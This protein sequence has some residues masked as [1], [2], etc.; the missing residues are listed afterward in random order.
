MVSREILF[1]GKRVDNGDWVEGGFTFDAALVPRITIIDSSGLGL[2]FI[3]VI[4]DSVGQLIYRIN[5]INVFDG[6]IFGF[7][8]S[9]YTYFI[10][11]EDCFQAMCYHCNPR[12]YDEFLEQQMRWGHFYRIKELGYEDRFYLIG[13]IHDNPELLRKEVDHG[14]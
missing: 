5:N 14:S 13:N 12:Y 4:P 8:G 2:E 9:D 11:V 6:D 3:K 7:K 1:R 10:R